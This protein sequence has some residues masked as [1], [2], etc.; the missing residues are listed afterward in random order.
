MLRDSALPVIRLTRFGGQPEAAQQQGQSPQPPPTRPLRA[1][2]TKISRPY[3]APPAKLALSCLTVRLRLQRPLM[4]PIY[5]LDV[6]LLLATTLA[7]KRRPADLAEIFSALDLIQGAIP[8]QAK[9]AEAFARLSSHGLV[10]AQDSG[11]ALTPEALKIVACPARKTEHDERLYDI[12]QKLAA[13]TPA[14][15][16]AAIVLTDA[17]LAAAI[18][19]HSVSAQRTGQNLLMP[20]PKPDDAK[21]APARGYARRKPGMGHRR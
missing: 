13:Y 6:L 4:H 5:D 10:C 9:L 2:R 17:Q 19:A 1:H 16:A 14:A 18:A 8:A 15:E 3:V 20:K 21:K 12:R 11:Y 7:A